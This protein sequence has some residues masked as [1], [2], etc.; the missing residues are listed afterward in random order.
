MKSGNVVAQASSRARAEGVDTTPTPYYGDSP[1][2][3]KDKVV[4]GYVRTSQTTPGAA[5]EPAYFERIAA[6]AAVN[7][8]TLA[9]TSRPMTCTARPTPP[10]RASS[11]AC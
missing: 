8:A 11:C 3:V 6:A 10:P 7:D 5:A 4:D 1:V 9:A 2:L